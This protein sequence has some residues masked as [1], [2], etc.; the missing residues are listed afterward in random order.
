MRQLTLN[1]HNI[2][3]FKR[4]AKSE[5]TAIVKWFDQ[6]EVSRKIVPEQSWISSVTTD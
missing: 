4:N 3:I 2:E 1:V 5:F 6:T